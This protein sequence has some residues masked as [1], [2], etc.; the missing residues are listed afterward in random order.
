MPYATLIYF[1]TL[2]EKEDY[3]ANQ[4]E[5]NTKRKTLILEKNKPFEVAEEIK[6]IEVI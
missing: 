1:E 6:E 2:K 3:E 4:N 5:I